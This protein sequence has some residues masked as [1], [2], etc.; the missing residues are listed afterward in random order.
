MKLLL[1]HK[2][3]L[4][5]AAT[6]KLSL[7]LVESGPTPLSSK[8]LLRWQTPKSLTL[9]DNFTKEIFPKFSFCLPFLYTFTASCVNLQLAKLC[10][11]HCSGRVKAASNAE[12]LPYNDVGYNCL[13]FRVLFYSLTFRLWYDKIK[14]I[15]KYF[16][17]FA[18]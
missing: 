11:R 3:A 6:A 1:F 15:T 14:I 18:L 10:R 17:V 5:F 2:L 8:L 7:L 12:L 13:Y 4:W 16:A 9:D